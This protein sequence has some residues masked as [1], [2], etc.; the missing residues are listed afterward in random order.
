MELPTVL[1]ALNF[2]SDWLEGGKPKMRKRKATLS[3]PIEKKTRRI[4]WKILLRSIDW[5]FDYILHA[6]IEVHRHR[7]AILLQSNG[8]ADQPKTRTIMPF[9]LNS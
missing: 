1:K 3:G 6:N 4:F 8:R 9:P 7:L 2:V 5:V